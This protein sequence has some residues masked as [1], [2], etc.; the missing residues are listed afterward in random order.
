MRLTIKNP[1]QESWAAMNGTE[2]A[3]F[4]GICQKHVYNLSAMTESEATGLLDSTPSV[5]I[6]YQPAWDGSV[7]F[8]TAAILAVSLLTA[9]EPTPSSCD[10]GST[11]VEIGMSPAS[12]TIPE[13]APEGSMIPEIASPPPEI[14]SSPPEV[15]VM[16]GEVAYEP[17]KEVMGKPAPPRMGAAPARI[18]PPK[19]E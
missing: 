19:S 15:P 1:C 7:L 17:P 18:H 16:M 2:Q 9:C 14:K 11:G 5:C 6:R 8:K 13:A 3:R 10:A 12:P 4:C